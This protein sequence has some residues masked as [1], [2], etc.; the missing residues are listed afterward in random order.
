MA[1]LAFSCSE[2]EEIV[3]PDTEVETPDENQNDDDQTEEPEVIY[4]TLT[5]EDEDYASDANYLGESNWSSLIDIEYGGD[6]LYALD[7]NWTGYSE[8]AWYDGGNTELASEVISAYGSSAY[9]NGGIALSNYYFEVSEANQATYLNQ[10]SV[11]CIDSN[12]NSGYNGSEN[13]AVIYQN[14]YLY[15][16]DGVA[17]TI[18]HLYVAPTSYWLS[19]ATYGDYGTAAMTDEDYFKII[20][21]SVDVEGEALATVELYLAQDGQKA[22]DWQEW[23]LS[24]LGQVTK[25]IFTAEGSVVNEWGSALPGYFAID[26]ITVVME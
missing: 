4:A 18:D 22:T 24:S 17:R 20:A 8:Y 23:D 13:F 9:W 14:G 16:G 3:T 19:M 2:D 10:L 21:T 12:G 26:D 15:F 1:I 5:F 11:P 25:V 7:E 6:L